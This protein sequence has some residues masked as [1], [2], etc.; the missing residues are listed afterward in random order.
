MSDRD[1]LV[2]YQERPTPSVILRYRPGSY[3]GEQIKA[4]SAQAERVARHV[5]R[6]LRPLNRAGTRFPTLAFS[7]ES[8]APVGK[9]GLPPGGGGP[10]RQGADLRMPTARSGDGRQPAGV[11][12]AG[13]ILLRLPVRAGR[14]EGLSPDGQGLPREP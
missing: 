11:R 8:D 7:L 9:R 14:T 13:R 3:A 2:E 4:L 5:E 6:R 10:R 12:R 1:H